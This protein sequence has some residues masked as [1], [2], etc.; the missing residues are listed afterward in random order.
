MTTGRLSLDVADPVISKFALEINEYKLAKLNRKFKQFDILT[1]VS[2]ALYNAGLWRVAYITKLGRFMQRPFDRNQTKRAYVTVV[3]KKRAPQLYY[4]LFN[5]EEPVK[6]NEFAEI[7]SYWI[8]E[9]QITA[10]N[11]EQYFKKNPK[12]L[13]EAIAGIFIARK[14]ACVYYL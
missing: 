7:L 2:I 3:L 10:Y 4:S 11:Y 1:D 12:V 14:I 6:L 5:E 9:L 13:N 8:D